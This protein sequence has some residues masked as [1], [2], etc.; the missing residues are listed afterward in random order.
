MKIVVREDGKTYEV[1]ERI[2][3][4]ACY[5]PWGRETQVDM[6]VEY[7]EIPGERKATYPTEKQKG[8]PQ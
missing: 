3:E 2:R 5:T 7:W 8:T 6:I 1:H 4:M